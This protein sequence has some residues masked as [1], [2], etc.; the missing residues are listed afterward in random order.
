MEEKNVLLSKKARSVKTGFEK[1][2]AELFI[3]LA[4]IFTY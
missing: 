1:K 2:N 4:L 3:Y